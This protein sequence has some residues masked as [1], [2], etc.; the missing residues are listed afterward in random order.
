MLVVY[1]VLVFAAVAPIVIYGWGVVWYFVFV[2]ILSL[3]L[4]V[5]VACGHRGPKLRW[6]WDESDMGDYPLG[7]CQSCGYDLPDDQSGACPECGCN[8]EDG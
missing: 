8:C 6:R 7:H 5:F 3:A 4:V 1:L 2:G